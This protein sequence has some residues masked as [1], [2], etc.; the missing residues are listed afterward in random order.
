[1]QNE[2]LSKI[3]QKL[4]ACGSSNKFSLRIIA[5]TAT[6]LIQLIIKRCQ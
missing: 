1:M 3:A 6:T 2:G 4:I 5:A